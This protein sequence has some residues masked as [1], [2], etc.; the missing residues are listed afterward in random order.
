MI[1]GYWIDRLTDYDWENKLWLVLSG[2]KD[3]SLWERCFILG[4]FCV[5]MVILLFLIVFFTT[6]FFTGFIIC[7]DIL[8]KCLWG[9]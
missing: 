3:Y 4:V 7:L 9:Y 2:S 5:D 1:I 8:L 6:S